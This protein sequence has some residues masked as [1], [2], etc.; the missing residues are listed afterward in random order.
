M[1][2]GTTISKAPQTAEGVYNIFQTAGISSRT[3]ENS[4]D[5]SSSFRVPSSRMR[6][7]EKP[8]VMRRLNGFLVGFEGEW[9]KVVYVQGNSSY[10]YNVPAQQLLKSGIKIENQP[11][12]MDEVEVT[13]DHEIILGTIF[14]PLASTESVRIEPLP[15]SEQEKAERAEILGYFSDAKT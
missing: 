5:D 13:L 12:E 3:S 1:S 8:R 10:E 9:A 7:R 15:L 14:R 11:F 2:A 6:K 4:K